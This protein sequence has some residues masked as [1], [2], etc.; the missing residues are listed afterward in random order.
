MAGFAAVGEGE[1]APLAVRVE[2]E[3][4]ECITKLPQISAGGR[5][6]L[7]LGVGGWGEG[8]ACECGWL[9]WGGVE[10]PRVW[11]LGDVRM[12]ASSKSAGMLAGAGPK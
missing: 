5:G 2:R 4:L 8:G 10:G 9:R 1:L 7:V 3:G 6:S 12:K 11:G